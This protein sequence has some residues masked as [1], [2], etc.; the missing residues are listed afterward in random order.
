M[1]N[2]QVLHILTDILAKTMKKNSGVG[3][4]KNGHKR[5]NRDSRKSSSPTSLSYCRYSKVEI[6]SLELYLGSVFSISFRS[7]Y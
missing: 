4:P 5:V 7:V 2:D 6:S 3:K 1:S